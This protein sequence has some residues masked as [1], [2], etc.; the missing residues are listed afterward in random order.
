M[1]QDDGRARVAA[2]VLD[3]RTVRDHLDDFAV[4]AGHHLGSGTHCSVSL[5]HLGEDR[6]AA[7]SSDRSAACDEVEYRTGAGPCVTAMDHLQVVLVP[8]VLDDT[9]WPSWREVTLAHGFRSAAAVPAHVAEGAEV[10]LNLYSDDVAPWD[11][12]ALVRA[13]MY[14]Q[15]IATAIELCL[16]VADLTRQVSDLRTARELQVTLDRAVGATMTER[17]VSA[18]GALAHLRDRAVAEGV[19]IGT[20]A[21]AVLRSLDAIEASAASAAPATTD[22]PGRG[23]DRGRSDGDTRQNRA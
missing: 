22:D 1:A 4:R 17:R 21:A 3:A 13:D 20:V 16:Q 23:P 10:A 12:D 11:R 9:R 15:Q 8:D 19:D 7:A 5:R 18:E 6:L 2:L 14:A